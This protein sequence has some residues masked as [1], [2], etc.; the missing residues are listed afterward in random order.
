M[1]CNQDSV[2]LISKLLGPRNRSNCL[3][4][5]ETLGTKIRIELILAGSGPTPSP[6]RICPKYSI[7]V[8]AKD[9]LDLLRGKLIFHQTLKN[10]FQVSSEGGRMGTINQNIIKKIR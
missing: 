7:E 1:F 2:I 6:N 9:T 4:L 3:A 10:Y 5:C 8:C